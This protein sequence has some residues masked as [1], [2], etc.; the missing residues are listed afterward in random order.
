MSDKIDLNALERK[1]YLAYYEDGLFDM[2]I[3]AAI[4][5]ISGVAL[6][7]LDFPFYLWYILGVS[8][9]TSA[10]N[11]ITVPR[12]GYVKFR[13]TRK[14][15]VRK[16]IYVFILVL[17]LIML[18]GVLLFKS[19]VALETPGWIFVIREYGDIMFGAI[20]LGGGLMSVGYTTE[21]KRFT[22][23]GIAAFTLHLLNHFLTVN[24]TWDIWQDMAPVNLLIGLVMLGNGYMHL[25][26]FKEKYPLTGEPKYE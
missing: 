3:G 10:K 25:R 11:Q 19:A 18:A 20:L 22:Y 1:A 23:Y 24:P 2:G 14:G 17:T 5:W 15:R 26:R 9:W 12:M 4:A 6:T 7:E 21:V 8:V 16:L 13:E